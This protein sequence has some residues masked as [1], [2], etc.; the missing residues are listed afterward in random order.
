MSDETKQEAAPKKKPG[1]PKKV[2]E[3]V[4]DTSSQENEELKA[5]LKALQDQVGILTGA[6]N[7]ARSGSLVESAP[8]EDKGSIEVVRLAGPAMSANLTDAYGRFKNFMW[9]NKGESMYLTPAQLQELRE[10]PGGS[11]FFKKGW[12]EVAGEDSEVERIVDIGE[13][14]AG[15]KIEDIEDVISSKE[16]SAFLIRILNYVE[17]QRVVTEDSNGNPLTDSE[18]NVYAEVKKLDQ[19]LRL[20]AESAVARIHELTG[21]RYSLS[22]G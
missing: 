8:S 11:Q 9:R 20:A 15:L 13:Y 1:R 6:L 3:E 4:V 18:G 5:Q 7:L 2:K 19:R 12:L 21:V 14:I 16:D 17:S 10:S 22:D